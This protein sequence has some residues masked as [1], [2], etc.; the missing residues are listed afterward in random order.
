MNKDEY[1]L[2]FMDCQM[3]EM[4]GYE[5]T[6]RIRSSPLSTAPR[7][8]AMTAN[9]LP[10]DRERCLESGMDDYM[11]KP[12]RPEAIGEIIRRWI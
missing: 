11:T 7:I 5:T 2:I 10:G 3:P 9:A 12:L 6:R 8:I 4:D 1:D